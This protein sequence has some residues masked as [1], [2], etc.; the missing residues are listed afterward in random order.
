MTHLKAWATDNRKAGK[1]RLVQ[2][3][4]SSDIGK[5]GARRR[6]LHSESSN[7]KWKKFELFDKSTPTKSPTQI[8]DKAPL[9]PY[10][11]PF[12]IYYIFCDCGFNFPLS[13]AM[14]AVAKNIQSFGSHMFDSLKFQGNNDKHILMRAKEK[15]KT[16]IDFHRKKQA[17]LLFECKW[18][19]FKQ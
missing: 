18:N 13:E 8:H 19:N 6:I 12:L 2:C 15:K 4:S 1:A 9:T 10:I 5:Y 11:T 3:D 7:F 16:A 14:K 17:F